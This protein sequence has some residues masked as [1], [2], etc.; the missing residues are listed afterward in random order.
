[1]GGVR[2]LM[3]NYIIFSF[4][5]IHPLDNAG[6]TPH[7]PLYAGEC[8]PHEEFPMMNMKTMLAKQVGSQVYDNIIVKLQ[9]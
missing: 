1:M 4:F 7:G 5:L 8:L 3:E 9:F 2:T 6:K